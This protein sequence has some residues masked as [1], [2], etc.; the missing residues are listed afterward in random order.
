[1]R[2]LDEENHREISLKKLGLNF[3]PKPKPK[4]E[5][6]LFIHV[7]GFDIDLTKTTTDGR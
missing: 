6:K 7:E 3:N 5:W 4:T 1:M 2:A